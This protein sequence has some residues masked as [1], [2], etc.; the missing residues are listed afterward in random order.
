MFFSFIF[1]FYSSAKIK[2]IFALL[3]LLPAPKFKIFS[4]FAQNCCFIMLVS[5]LVVTLFLALCCLASYPQQVSGVPE[6]PDQDFVVASVL[7]ISDGDDVASSMGHAAL[8]LTCVSHG[9]DFVFDVVQEDL[10]PNLFRFAS[11]RLTNRVNISNSSDYINDYLAQGRSITAYRL[12]LPIAV[13]QRLWQV[14]DNHA[15]EAPL[16]L[17]DFRASC[18]GRLF[19]WIKEAAGDSVVVA[20]WPRSFACSVYE[21]GYS[22]FRHDWS[23]FVFGSI[24]QGV[25]TDASVS[26]ELKIVIPATLEDVLKSSMAFGHPLVEHVDVLS[27]SVQHAGPALVSPMVVALMLLCV[28]VF[29]L[30]ARRP[31]VSFVVLAFPLVLGALVSLLSLMSRVDCISFSWLVIPFSPLPWLFFRFRRFWLLP[32]CLICL[33]WS[34]VMLASP[35]RLVLDVHVVLALASAVAYAQLALSSF[36]KK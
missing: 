35:H 10:L 25:V 34:V 11:G 30:Y 5:R 33:L 20:S 28:A 8:R 1:L 6:H 12:A 15:S 17:T 3:A 21:I 13:K 27:P 22:G 18:S 19:S 29:N 7:V 31:V 24:A 36:S 4:N 2:K 32:M 9:L 26:N 16:P 14:M 23:Q